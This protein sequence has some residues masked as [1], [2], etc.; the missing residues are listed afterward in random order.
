MAL[1]GGMP[2][3]SLAHEA[4]TM[5]LRKGGNEPTI[6]RVR[7]ITKCVLPVYEFNFES[8]SLSSLQHAATSEG[9]VPIPAWKQKLLE[10]KVIYY[11]AKRL[12]I[13]TWVL[14]CKNIQFLNV[15]SQVW[16]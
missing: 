15:A 4:L 3:G 6:Q 16:W 14:R 7:M 11:S 13:Y 10:R 12:S 5:K 1:A 2:G 9:D 8:N